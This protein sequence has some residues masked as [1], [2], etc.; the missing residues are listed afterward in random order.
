[1]ADEPLWRPNERA[2][3]Q[4]RLAQ[5][6][7]EAAH[8]FGIS[9]D[10][11][12]TLHRQSV[13]YPAQFWS[14]LWDFTNVIGGKGDTILVNPDAMPGARWFPQARLN[15][16]EN[17]LRGRST[18]VALIYR[19]ERGVRSELTMG[20]LRRQVFSLAQHMR[21]FGVGTG[22]RVAAMVPN[23]IETVVAMLATTSLG[24]VWSSCSPDFGSDAVVDRFGQIEPGILIACDGYSYNGR[25]YDLKEKV[26]NVRTRLPSVSHVIV[27]QLGDGGAGDGNVALDE[28]TADHARPSFT[29]RAFDDPL[30]IM[31]SSG[32]TGPPKCIVHSVGGTL[33]QHLKEHQ[34]HCDL[35][36]GDRV[37]YFT[38]C[39][40]MMWNWLVS[41][42]ASDV[43]V[44]LYE[45]SPFQPNAEVILRYI[46]EEALTCYGT[47]P[48]YLSALAKEGVSPRERFELA[49]LNQ[50]LST[51][52]PLAPELFEWFYAN[53]KPQARLA[54]I[55]GGTD[56]MGCFA[57]GVPTL[58]VYAGELQGPAL[59]MAVEFW[60]EHGVARETGKGELVC[61]RPFPSMPVGFWND[62]DGEKY[63]AAYFSRYEGVWHHGDFGE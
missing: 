22:D 45:G 3:S 57:L 21:R 56:I 29:P 6:Q 55:S 26:Q 54:S 47:S 32:T 46:E 19:D 14:R 41:A 50:V 27:I 34:L 24:A 7:R 20:A 35:G 60:D 44:C 37:L 31:F 38:T 59:G 42:L 39:G 16:A 52:S 53:F 1:M 5:F 43:T 15:F 13:A 2:L 12:A 58:P 61:T 11:Y 17:L 18:K 28:L 40:W 51:G 63:H 25:W 4:S 8:E 62:P 9:I 49:E 48:A 30:Y 10:D 23:C 33:L 36:M